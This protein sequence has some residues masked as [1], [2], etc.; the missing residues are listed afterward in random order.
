MKT[1]LLIFFSIALFS[2]ALAQEWIDLNGGVDGAITDITEYNGKLVVVGNFMR[3]GGIYSPHMAFWDGNNWEAAGMDSLSIIPHCL[4][5]NNDTL[6]SSSSYWHELLYWNGT[7]W[8]TYLQL[9][10]E[11]DRAISYHNEIY[12]TPYS[13]MLL[14]RITNDTILMIGQMSGGIGDMTIYNDQL[15]ATGCFDYIN[16]SRFGHI[17]SYDGTT[18]H[19]VANGF[20]SGSFGKSLEILNGMLY[21]GGPISPF[22]DNIYY[23]L[24][25]YD[26][27][28]FQVAS[29]QPDCQIIDMKF[30]SD[31]LFIN[32]INDSRYTVKLLDS[33]SWRTIGEIEIP[34]SSYLYPTMISF[35]NKLYIAGE[36]SIINGATYNN[37]ARWEETSGISQNFITKIKQLN[38]SP[39][40]A[41]NFVSIGINSYN[42]NL[43][44]ELTISDINGKQLQKQSLINNSQIINIENLPAGIYI[45]KVSNEKEVFVGKLVKQ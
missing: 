38:I 33:T 5:V 31:N 2:N 12:F 43:N 18:W 19:L 21:I 35:N 16:G 9:P 6:F 28:I 30:V 15:F 44:S 32:S 41:N 27:S 26:N 4:I 8:N 22:G 36:F 10:S 14:Y 25:T 23:G 37:I 34:N 29:V 1:V 45:V 20:T 11:A 3:A 17:A 24:L 40:P 42:S 7:D 39:N 13:G